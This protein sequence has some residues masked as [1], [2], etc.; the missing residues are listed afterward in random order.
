VLGDAIFAE[1]SQEEA[2]LT[3]RMMPDYNHNSAVDIADYTMWRDTLGSISELQADGDG[4]GTVDTADY[5]R[6]KEFFGVAEVA[7]MGRA[8]AIPEP[9]TWAVLAGLLLIRRRWPLL[10]RRG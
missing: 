9:S 8:S 1:S 5:A 6:W 7:P 3:I 10:S 4:N 2:L